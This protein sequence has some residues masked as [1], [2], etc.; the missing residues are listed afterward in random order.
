M[1]ARPDIAQLTRLFTSDSVSETQQAYLLSAA[2]VDDLRRRH[3]PDL[4]GRIAARVTDGISFDRAFQQETGLTA[5]AAAARAWEGYRRWT[6]W[7]PAVTSPSA[8]WTLILVIAILAFVAQR[9]RRTARR[10]QWDDDDPLARL[11]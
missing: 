11:D 9:R 6:A 7:V 2:L 5:D 1:L 3:G 8:A 4:P 10:R